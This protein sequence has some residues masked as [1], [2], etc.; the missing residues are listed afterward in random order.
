M[1]DGMIARPRATSSRTNSGVTSSGRLAPQA[2]PGCWLARRLPPRPLPFPLLWYIAACR[3]KFS[4]RAM[5][6][7]SGVM[8]PLRA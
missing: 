6:Y 3:F 4:R 5:N 8:M 1:F 2:L 7:I